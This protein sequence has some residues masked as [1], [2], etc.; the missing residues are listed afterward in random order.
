MTLR[1]DRRFACEP[2]G[3]R[4]STGWGEVEWLLSP[5]ALLDGAAP[6]EVL[7]SDSASVLKAARAEFLA[8]G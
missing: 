7:V 4:R 2:D 3:L 6:A 1:G 8:D 5:H